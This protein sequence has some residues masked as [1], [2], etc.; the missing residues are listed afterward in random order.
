MVLELSCFFFCAY[1]YIKKS[2]N[3]LFA[4]RKL[5][6]FQSYVRKQFAEFFKHGLLFLQLLK[7]L[8]LRDA[9]GYKGVL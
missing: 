4:E 5:Q 2:P 6:G 7:Q 8:Y 3:I 9:G 1:P